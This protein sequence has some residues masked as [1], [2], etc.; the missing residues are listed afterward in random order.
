MRDEVPRISTGNGRVKMGNKC[1]MFI[2]RDCRTPSAFGP[3]SA[4]T[5][6]PPLHGHARPSIEEF[7][8]VQ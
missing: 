6:P 4:R 7:Q 1:L 8:F 2:G 3:M 5:S